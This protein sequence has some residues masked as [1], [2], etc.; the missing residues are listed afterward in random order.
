MDNVSYYLLIPRDY[1][2]LL[3]GLR[4]SYTGEAVEYENGNTFVFGAEIAKFLEGFTSLRP[5][6][7]FPYVLHLFHLL[8]YGRSEP[9]CEALELRKTFRYFGKPL[10]NAGALCAVLCRYIPAL[11]DSVDVKEICHRLSCSALMP[12]LYLG[13]LVE[14]PDGNAETPP[15]K[16]AVFEARVLTVLAALTPQE[17]SHWLRHGCG[18]VPD[19]GESIAREVLAMKPRTLDG[20]LA[21]LA[22]TPRLTGAIPFVSQLV[23]AL[24]LPPRKLVE[25]ELPMGGYADVAT[26]GDP[27]RILPSQFA[28]DELEFVRRYAEN[29]LL[30]FRREEPHTQTREQL[31]VLLDQGVRT[32]GIVRLLLGAAVLAF[33]KLAVRRKVPLLLAATS[34]SGKLLDPLEADDR[35]VRELVEA[36]DLTANPGLALEC[37]LEEPSEEARDVVL[38]THPRSLREPDVAAAARRV[39]P[40]TRLFAVTIEDRG[41]VQLGEMKHGMPVKLCQFQVDLTQGETRS[42]TQPAR[43]ADADREPLAPWHGDVEP[44]GFPF[45]FGV[46]SQLDRRLFAFDHSGEWLLAVGLND[47]LH[48]CKI[49]GSR[50]EILPRGMV[51]GR[52]LTKV[53]KILGV[54]G[55]FVVAGRID[56]RSVVMHYDFSTRKC[57]AH[58]PPPCGTGV[59]QWFYFREH[60]TV[61]ERRDNRSSGVDLSSGAHA[62]H[63]HQRRAL[64]RAER[65]CDEAQDYTVPPPRALIL[66]SDDPRPKRGATVR[67]DDGTGTVSV[68]GVSPKWQPFTPLAD[69]LPVLKNCRLIDAA[70]RENI[71]AMLC[72]RRGDAG[73]LTLRLFMGPNGIPI[74]E[75]SYSIHQVGFALSDDG[76]LLARQTENGRLLQVHESTTSGPPMFVTPHGRFHQRLVV[77]LGAAWLIVQIGKLTHLIRWDQGP[78]VLQHSRMDKVAFIAKEF[79]V[80]P[81]LSLSSTIVSTWKTER[82]CSF[83]NYDPKR[84][85]LRIEGR[86]QVIVDIFGQIAVLD[87]SGIL[88]CM[89]YFFRDQVAIW[90]P[91]GTRYGLPSVCQGPE[92]PNALEKI[93]RALRDACERGWKVIP[94]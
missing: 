49:D 76:R 26:R 6:I 21:T 4:W 22:Q 1:C 14:D 89:F 5:L 73:K 37:V 24:A 90:M 57:T 85:A 43:P 16:S 42:A 38:L 58:T 60:H 8:G 56:D 64:L 23:S 63:R 72:Y 62:V 80:S 54:A 2:Q 17:L 71:L 51:D 55:G 93:G 36:S 61:V 92:T 68:E 52:L 47:M 70:H 78:L 11:A 65:A 75:Y 91:D 13:R 40:G 66:S 82:P 83:R 50:A 46:T 69:G 29:E 33:G 67:L 9:P 79:S 39:T 77:E 27:E 53:D 20:I 84:F 74:G 10:R 59:L 18:P 88:V 41:S 15:L 44:I 28:M 94:S 25:H 3:A 19:K 34:S 7:P 45:W 87:S 81:W 31:V 12:V 32:W 35:A 30:Y 48:A 86:C